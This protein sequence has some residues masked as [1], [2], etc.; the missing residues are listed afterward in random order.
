MGSAK[1]AGLAGDFLAGKASVAQKRRALAALAETPSEASAAVLLD[2]SKD[3]QLQDLAEA[4]L[5]GYPSSF[6]ASLVARRLRTE[7]DKNAVSVLESL[8]ARFSQ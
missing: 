1:G 6:M 4:L 8:D 7:T 5:E 3:A 2:A